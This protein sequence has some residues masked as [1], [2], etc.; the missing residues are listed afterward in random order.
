[1]PQV[2]IRRRFR[3]LDLGDQLGFSHTVFH[4]DRLDERDLGGRQRAEVF[5]GVTRS[6]KGAVRV[7]QRL[8]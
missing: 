2:T 5:G 4:I 7:V 8:T 1:M 3:E 6:V